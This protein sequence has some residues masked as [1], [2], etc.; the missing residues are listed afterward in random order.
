[1]WARTGAA[2]TPWTTWTRRSP[3]PKPEAVNDSWR[4]KMA[5]P[6]GSVQR[7]EAGQQ[8]P[9]KWHMPLRWLKACSC[10]TPSRAGSPFQA[11]RRS[12]PHVRRPRIWC[13][14]RRRLCCGRSRPFKVIV[15]PSK[16][17]ISFLSLPYFLTD[18]CFSLDNPL[19][20]TGPAHH[21]S[22]PCAK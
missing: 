22:R 20:S 17:S 5:V 4:A 18:F 14:P 12:L 15:R 8:M 2:V 3:K 7:T 21:N 1:M 13:W 6:S 19:S 10:S 9:G 11:K 16:P